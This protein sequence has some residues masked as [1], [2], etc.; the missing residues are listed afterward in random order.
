MQ[1]LLTILFLFFYITTYAGD[2]L[3]ANRVPFD[4]TRDPFVDLKQA[5]AEAKKENKN[6][7]LDVGGEWCIWC[8]RIDEFITND[9]E[10]KEGFESAFV[11][12][13]VNF[14]KENK[15]EKFLSQYP[16]IPGY[17]HFFILDK[18]G[19]FLESQDTGELESGKSYSKQKFLEFVNKWKNKKR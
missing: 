11:I 15:N 2:T 3:S 5:V 4:P 19:K 6:I 12:L 9:K 7:L 10:I 8:H 16:K 17:P 14:S 1:T 18:N 13:K